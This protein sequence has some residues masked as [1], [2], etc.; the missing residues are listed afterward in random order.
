[1]PVTVASE[2][3]PSDRTS[4]TNSRAVISCSGH[5]W[6]ISISSVRSTMAS[7]MR[8]WSKRS[9]TM[10]LGDGLEVRVLNLD[11]LVRM[12]EKLSRDKDRLMLIHLRH[13]LKE[14]QALE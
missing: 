12:K 8:I 11:E 14:S 10:E 2:I 5:A 13:V 7:A 9:T 3:G 6:A 1:M 4:R